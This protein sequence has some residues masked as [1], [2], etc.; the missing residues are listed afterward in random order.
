MKKIL[1]VFGAAAAFSAFAEENTYEAVERGV[2]KTFEY[3]QP[4]ELPIVFSGWSKAENADAID[5]CIWLD[6]HYDNG[7][8]VW[9]RKAEFRRGTHDWEEARGVFVPARP[10]VKIT[11]NA[12]FRGRGELKAK[13]KVSFR[14][15]RLERRDGNNETYPL[16]KLTDR[17]FSNADEYTSEIFRGRKVTR[18]KRLVPRSDPMTSPVTSGTVAVWTEDSMRLVTP[19]TF[20][21]AHA[22]N[23]ISLSLA[24]RE[25]ESA[26][27]LLSAAA[28]TE[29]KSVTLEL[30]VLRK[31]DGTPLKGTV[32]WQRQGY[33]AREYGANPHP[34]AFPADE[35]WFPDPLMPPA[36]MR[37][38]KA[39]TQ[40]AW[41]TVYAAP[42][43]EA[44]E[45]S[46]EVTVRAGGVK[47]ARVLMT[48]SVEP[49]A[50]PATFGLETAYA[51]MDGYTRALYPGDFKAKKREA[52]DIMLDHRLNPDDI[53]RTTPPDIDDLLYARNRGM[54]RFNILN[55]VPP[56]KD[57]KARCVFIAKPEEIFNEKFYESFIG[58]VKPY[59]AELR[60]HG[61]DKYAYIYGFDERKKEFYGGIDAFWTKLKRDVPGIPLMTTA[62][63]YQDFAAGRTNIPHLVT[64]DWYCPTT[65]VYDRDVSDRLRRL[66]K[67]VWWY[68]CCSPYYPYANFSSW[69]YPLIEGRILGWMTHRWRADGFLFW[70]VNKWNRDDLFKEDDTYFPDYR[71]YN[72]NGMPG[73]G[74][75][76]YPGEKHIFPSIKLA[77]CR[78]AVEDYEYL[79]LAAA[80]AGLAAADSVTDSIVKSLVDFTRDPAKLRLARKRLVTL[81]VEN[82]N[83]GR[84]LAGANLQPGTSRTPDQAGPE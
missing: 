72:G 68:T 83:V 8:A 28:D 14:N 44:G 42:E 76:M 70:I 33:L 13:G 77:Q 26:Q 23:F 11:V 49:F 38:R 81:I 66:G 3:G 10:V 31:T 59:V 30:P 37:V 24:K 73:D 36:P 5:Y 82:E 12:L 32:S 43:A 52:I 15:F 46:G 60:K 62:K 18:E 63:N 17:P 41:V 84:G 80:K 39:S 74:I 47:K 57:P 21:T 50:L 56:P 69:E 19:L 9:G 4:T 25:R 51:L 1:F 78:D 6:L 58:T 27:I 75:M 71:T 35:K 34:F 55:V 61:L 2:W 65:Q 29:W 54:N 64:G 20:P 48:V 40:G 16:T 22:R 7:E 67:K 53:S 79:Q 45:Y